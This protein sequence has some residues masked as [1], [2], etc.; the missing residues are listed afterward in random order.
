VLWREI[1]IAAAARM[2]RVIESFTL[3]ESFDVYR[4]REV[5]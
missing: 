2:C 5:V 4:D 1:F 3:L